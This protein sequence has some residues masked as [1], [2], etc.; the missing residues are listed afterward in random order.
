M[1]LSFSSLKFRNL[2]VIH[3]AGMISLPNT[4]NHTIFKRERNKINMKMISASY[5][6]S[7]NSKIGNVIREIRP[8]NKEKFELLKSVR[9]V[10]FF[11][12]TP[13]QFG[14]LL[15]IT[16]NMCSLIKRITINA[17]INLMTALQPTIFFCCLLC[18]YIIFSE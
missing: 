15:D 11:L 16:L 8:K 1:N 5:E 9:C 6:N 12:P 7:I 3:Y 13:I 2:S 14:K 18:C 17:Y 4:T 10:L